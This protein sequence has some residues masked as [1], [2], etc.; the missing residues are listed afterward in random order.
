MP[1]LIVMID[2]KILFKLKKMEFRVKSLVEGKLVGIHRSPYH[3][4]SVEFKEHRSYNPGDPLKYVDWKVYART[5]KFFVKLFE[6][7]TNLTAWILVDVSSSM[8]YGEPR[9]FDYAATLA[10]LWSYLLIQQKDEVGLLLFSDK[11]LHELPPSS[12]RRQL[13]KI[14]E[15]LDSFKPIGKTNIDQ[16][17]HKVSDNLTRK[18]VVILISDLWQPHEQVLPSLQLV[19]TKDNHMMVFH[20]ISN[21][22]LVL[23]AER[24]RFKDLE[25]NDEILANPT[26]IRDSYERLL[27]AWIDEYR[28]NCLKYQ[29]AYQFTPTYEPIEK[30]VLP[31][32]SLRR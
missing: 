21:D 4:F 12:T 2:P 8:D 13:F 17:L 22:E 3:G 20:V 30:I 19:R 27:K 5:D 16:A 29:I 1:Y 32:L 14:F 10:A 7:E 18:G 11:V 6:Q 15:L 24:L 26:D 23:P 9:K 31:F 28:V 25:V